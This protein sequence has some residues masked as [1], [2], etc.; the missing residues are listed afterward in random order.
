MGFGDWGLG[1]E[2]DSHFFSL[3]GIENFFLLSNKVLYLKRFV[4]HIVNSELRIGLY[5]SKEMHQILSLG[6]MDQKYYTHFNLELAESIGQAVEMVCILN[7]YR[8]Q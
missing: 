5:F 1:I 8:F 7:N 2:T 4:S 6:L 3:M